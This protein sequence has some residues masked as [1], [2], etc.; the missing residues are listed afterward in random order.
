MLDEHEICHFFVGRN[1]KEKG[2]ERG[3]FA[4]INFV[5]EPL[6]GDA[7]SETKIAVCV[8]SLRAFLL[9]SL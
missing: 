2:N 9:V 4:L 6:F 7:I 1:G 5:T 8:R 3:R